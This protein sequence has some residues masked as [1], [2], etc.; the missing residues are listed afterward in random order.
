MNTTIKDI[1]ERRSC[2]RFDPEKM[3]SEEQINEI[4][5]CGKYAP[6]GCG[7]QNTKMI[8][9]T[10]R[11]VRDQ[12][13][14]MNTEVW[15]RTTDPFYGAPMMI[16]VLA[17]A[18]W[19]NRVYD[20]SLVMGNLM[21]AAHALGIDS[22][23]IHRAKEEFESEEGKEILRSLGLVPEEWEGIGHC[24]LGFRNHDI[25]KPKARK[26]DFVHWIK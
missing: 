22:I 14:R 4:L 5:E 2:R 19:R 6:N 13:S 9:V 7:F 21:L 17:K 16:I 24:A 26:E 11:E 8:V 23:W 15:G 3:P 20:G 10:N 12:I 25:P 1:L 18:D